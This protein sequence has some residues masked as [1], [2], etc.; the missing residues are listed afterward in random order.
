MKLCWLKMVPSYKHN[1]FVLLFIRFGI[2]ILLIAGLTRMN[3]IG[4][5][6]PHGEVEE[7]AGSVSSSRIYT[8][9]FREEPDLLPIR[10]EGTVKNIPEGNETKSEG[11]NMSMMDVMSLF[12]QL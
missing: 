7:Q 9:S 8:D 1:G 4:Q 11:G 12:R 3:L 10:K 2:I 6:R 5:W